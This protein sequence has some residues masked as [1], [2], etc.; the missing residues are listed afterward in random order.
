MNPNQYKLPFIFL[1][2]F[3]KTSLIAQPSLDIET[4]AV[5]SGYNNVRIPGNLGTNFSLK[6][7]LKPQPQLFY[8]LRGSYL[9]KKRHSLSLLYAP[10][11]IKSKGSVEKDIFFEGV[12]FPANTQLNGTY[13]FNSYRLTYRYDIISK[14]KF[15]WGLGFTGKIRDAKIALSSSS[16]SSEKTNVGFVPIIHFRVKWQMDNRFGILLDGDALA[17]PQGRAEDIQ[18]AATYQWSDRMG[19][20]VGYRILEGGA[21]NNEVYNFTLIHYASVGMT[22]TFINKK[23]V[24]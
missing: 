9:I 4:G 21:E 24:K 11:T 14:P 17:A 5:F 15:V 6:N 3:C 18:L 2:I 10:L 20:R 13:Q 7:D 22:Y 16:L 12:L 1:L 19:L 23:A 8:R